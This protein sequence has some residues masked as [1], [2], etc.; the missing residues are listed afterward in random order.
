MQNEIRESECLS[1]QANGSETVSHLVN[2]QVRSIRGRPDPAKTNEYNA[3]LRQVAGNIQNEKEAV[4]SE[5]A[6]LIALDRENFKNMKEA[7]ELRREMASER[8]PIF[9][10][11]KV[12]L[13]IDLGA[14]RGD[15]RRKN[16]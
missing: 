16:R 15:M 10:D 3:F 8:F 9:V 7:D 14:E 13:L 12:Y 11:R 5:V 4:E 2:L 1:I 6:E